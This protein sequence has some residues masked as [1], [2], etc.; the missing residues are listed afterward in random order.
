MNWP[1]VVAFILGMFAWVAG[2][3]IEESPRRWVRFLAYAYLG[4]CGILVGRLLQQ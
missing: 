4:A 1:I 3:T 2:E